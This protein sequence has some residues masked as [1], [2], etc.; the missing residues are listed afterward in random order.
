[1]PSPP[2]DRGQPP[3][4]GR[5]S[6]CPHCGLALTIQPDATGTRVIFSVEDWR[7]LCK[8]PHLDSPTLCLAKQGLHTNI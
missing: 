7:R 5:P 6:A 3:A 1:V 2:H 4:P 8:H